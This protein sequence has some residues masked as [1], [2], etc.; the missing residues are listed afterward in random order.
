MKVKKA[1]RAKKTNARGDSSPAAEPGAD[2]EDAAWVAEVAFEAPV[3]VEPVDVVFEPVDVEPLEVVDA[4]DEEEEP[5]EV[6]EDPVAVVD[7]LD[8]EEEPVDED[9]ED[10]EAAADALLETPPISWT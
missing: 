9:P 10:V 3:D 6:V 4:E 1:A 7:A 5:V 8:D 2:V